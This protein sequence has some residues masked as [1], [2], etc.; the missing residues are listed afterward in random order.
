MTT[1]IS[2]PGGLPGSLKGGLVAATVF[3]ACWG[4]AIWYWR[5]ADV[6]PGSVE[7]A[8]ALLVLPLALVGSLW[9]GRKLI[10]A[11]AAAPAAAAAGKP[12]AAQPV[13]AALPPLAIVS[14][15]L[16][17]PHGGSAEE[18]AAVL[19]ENK[20]R[21]DLDR[22][23]IDGDGFPIMA[24]RCDEAHDELLQEQI[25]EWL[26]HSGM[27]ALRFS[28]EQWRALTLGSAVVT[29]L[30]G[31]A[32]DLL[33]AEGTPP[34]L[35]LLPLLPVDW[36]TEQHRA[37]VLWFR[38]LISQFGWPTTRI[39]V[40]KPD[41]G[42]ATPTAIFKRLAQDA[43]ATAAPTVAL[44]LACDSHI[45]QETVDRWDADDSLFTSTRPQ[46]LI[47]GE[48]ACGLLLSDLRT[49]SA[50][51]GALFALLE[52]AEEAR[53]ETSANDTRRVDPKL[54]RE[55]AERAAGHADILLADIGM[56]VTDAG[57]RQ[58][59]VLEV[60]GLASATMPQLDD[61]A[62]VACVGMA[63]GTCGE[64]PFLTALALAQ[65]RALIQDSPV[66]CI[67]NEDAYRRSTVLVRPVKA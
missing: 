25:E 4:G 31:R 28:D 37:A 66:L 21:A 27:S 56:I 42:V 23:L 45:G 22:E 8:L 59:R 54:L 5:G 38:H 47:P 3:A 24:A 29:E 62:D 6:T 18:L 14:S 48:G 60:M 7:L 57:Q 16:R 33:Q 51:D 34:L 10:A 64:V 55:L 58:N 9:L 65:H 2:S 53:H 19:A 46:G 63:S 35:R 39:D 12:A 11:R 40:P 61:T 49:A 52:P 43:A 44:V 30:A 17:S 67:G 13:T 36:R 1:A 20:A 41:T 32:G 26:A 50:I 15:A